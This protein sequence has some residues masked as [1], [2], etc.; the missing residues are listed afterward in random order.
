[1]SGARG[2][3]GLRLGAARGCYALGEAL[4]LAGIGKSRL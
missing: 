4:R 3:G 1:M 2:I